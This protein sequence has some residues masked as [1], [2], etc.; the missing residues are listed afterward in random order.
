[1]VRSFY[2]VDRHA[3]ATLL[4]TA[5]VVSEGA[6]V[7]GHWCGSTSV[8]LILEEALDAAQQR[9]LRA[10]PHLRV[11]LIRI[12][13]REASARASG[14]LESVRAE[15]GLRFEG[16]LLRMTVDVD[17]AVGHARSRVADGPPTR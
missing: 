15:L 16:R 12:A 7:D 8:D 1:V 10:C 2:R 13:Q 4:A 9:A 11:Q 6:V 14:P 17:A 5:D 3:L